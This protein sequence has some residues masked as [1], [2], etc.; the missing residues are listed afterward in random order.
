MGKDWGE[1]FRTLASICAVVMFLTGAASYVFGLI[2]YAK[3]AELTA[4]KAEMAQ[5]KTVLNSVLVEQKV[6]QELQW[7]ERV[8]RLAD[9]LQR[10]PPE[11]PDYTEFRSQRV[12]AQQQLRVVRDEL[13]AARGRQ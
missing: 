12:A 9:R 6:S 2:P 7:M 3:A 13:T 11:S 4:V 10:L 8:D 1:K 5:V